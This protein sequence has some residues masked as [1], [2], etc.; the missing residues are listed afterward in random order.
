ML[1]VNTAFI[2]TFLFGITNVVV[3]LEISC[4]TTSSD[5]HFSNAY[6]EFA[7]AVILTVSPSKYVT[8]P[9]PVVAV[10][11]TADSVSSKYVFTVTVYCTS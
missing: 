8:T 1:S 5:V 6:P 10:P 3:V 11:P 9:P 7:T 2:V 4:G